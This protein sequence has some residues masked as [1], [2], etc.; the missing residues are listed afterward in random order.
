MRR[1]TSIVAATLMALGLPLG[2][3]AIADDEIPVNVTVLSTEGAPEIK[4]Q[5]FSPVGKKS[6]AAKLSVSLTGLE[7]NKPEFFRVTPLVDAISRSNT[8]ASG[9]LTSKVELPYG[10]EPGMHITS[11]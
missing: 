3:A 1:L 11:G 4:A 7:P 2:Q 9:N 8:D 10:L 6:D 5:F